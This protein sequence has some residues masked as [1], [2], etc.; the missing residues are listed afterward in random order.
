MAAD[1][2]PRH[3]SSPL[4]PDEQR[5]AVAEYAR[6]QRAASV[7]YH[8]PTATDRF[9]DAAMRAAPYAIA[10]A[11]GAWAVHWAWVAGSPGLRGAM[12]IL[13]ACFVACWV[14][15]RRG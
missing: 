10:A 3:R 4:T 9:A 13:G 5:R 2:A 1:L 6:Q 7:R 14:V 8:R 12:V 15:V 11:A